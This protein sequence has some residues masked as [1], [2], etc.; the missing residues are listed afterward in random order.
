MKELQGADPN[1]TRF[2]ALEAGAAINI[3]PDLEQIQAEPL[4]TIA[5]EPAP[6][7]EQ[8]TTEDWQLTIVEVVRGDAAWELVQTANRFNEPPAARMHYLAVQM[9]VRYIGTSDEARR[10]Y[11]HSFAIQDN[12]GIIYEAP[13]VVGPEPNIDV[14][15][16]PG[17]E[18]TGWLILQ[19]P[20]QVQT[21]TLRYQPTFG[22]KELNTRYMVL[23]P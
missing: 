16:Y 19:A 18:H 8:V 17:G 12:D 6:Y 10:V 13:S 20:R 3:S 14:N 22:N 4:G 23:Q 1:D 2:L 7:G 11:S 21:V 9:H 5:E 15:L